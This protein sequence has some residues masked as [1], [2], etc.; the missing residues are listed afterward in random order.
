M[1]TLKVYYKFFISNLAVQS[2]ETVIIA[3]AKN[4]LLVPPTW[5]ASKL[6]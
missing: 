6:R 5:K 3:R 1:K 2:L 4:Y